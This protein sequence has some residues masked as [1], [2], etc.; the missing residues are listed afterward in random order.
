[1]SQGQAGSERE[2]RAAKEPDSWTIAGSRGNSKDILHGSTS[3][4][5][6]T[7]LRAKEFI[8]HGRLKMRNLPPS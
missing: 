7:Q 3:S 6:Q 8:G 2:G 1:M 4:H 5:V